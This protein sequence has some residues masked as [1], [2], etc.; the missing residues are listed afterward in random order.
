MDCNASANK[1][2]YLNNT[3]GQLDNTKRAEKQLTLVIDISKINVAVF[4]KSIVHAGP[5]NN[6]KSFCKTT[7]VPA[8]KC[9]VEIK[10][11]LFSGNTEMGTKIAN[12]G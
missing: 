11:T 3:E 8:Q 2:E 6:I 10:I 4:L 5:R 9:E 1:L 12:D 7:V